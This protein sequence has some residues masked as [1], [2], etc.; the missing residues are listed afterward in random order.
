MLVAQRKSGA[1]TLA[2]TAGTGVSVLGPFST[3]VIC[4]TTVGSCRVSCGLNRAKFPSCCVFRC[5]LRHSKPPRVDVVCCLVEPACGTLNK[6]SLV[7]YTTL[8]FIYHVR[9]AYGACDGYAWI[10]SSGVARSVASLDSITSLQQVPSSRC[11]DNAALLNSTAAIQA[12]AYAY[13]KDRITPMVR[14]SSPPAS[15]NF[16]PYSSFCVACRL[17]MLLL[18]DSFV[19]DS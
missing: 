14:R 19:V 12:C 3:R 9:G 7:L 11:G 13:W 15:Y 1:F 6:P 16:N 2:S 17:A 4:G 18:L 5:V 10:I 8:L